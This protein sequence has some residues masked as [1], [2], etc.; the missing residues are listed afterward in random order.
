MK[1]SRP[2]LENTANRETKFQVIFGMDHN[3]SMKLPKSKYVAF[4][5]NKRSIEM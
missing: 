2:V 3:L 4:K 5:D 1:N